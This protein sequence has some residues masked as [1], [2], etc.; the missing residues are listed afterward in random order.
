MKVREGALPVDRAVGRRVRM[1]R[2]GRGLSQG[3]L[4]DA[5]GVTF[6][7]VQ[8][9]ELGSNRI[10]ASKLYEIA[11]FLGVEVAELF[12]DAGAAEDLIVTGPDLPRRIDLL[13]AQGLANLPEGQVKEHLTA[14]ILAL[15]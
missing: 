7:Q 6:Q 5:L 11:R 15:A 8:K 3:R 14:L 4:A 13:V 9:Y 10:S 12:A 1:L 2:V